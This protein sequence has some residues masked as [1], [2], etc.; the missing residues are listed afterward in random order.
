VIRLACLVTAALTAVLAVLGHAAVAAPAPCDTSPD[1][2]RWLAADPPDP[3][4]AR[5]V[6]AVH[7]GGGTIAPEETLEAYTPRRVRIA[8]AGDPSALASA[9][10]R[11]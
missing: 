8:F 1:P 9:G 2:A 5:A 10:R 3:A 11:P 7:R 6:F 4:P